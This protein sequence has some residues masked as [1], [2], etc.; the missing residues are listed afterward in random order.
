MNDF[1]A[2]D[3]ETASRSHNSACALGLVVVNDGA[4]A[5]KIKWFIR[6]PQNEYE[7]INISIHGIT[8]DQTTASPEF[9]EVWKEAQSFI[10]KNLVVA[11][12]AT[13]SDIS[14]IRDSSAHFDYTPNDFSYVCTRDM[15]RLFWPDRISYG[16]STLSAEFGIDLD[17]HDP[18]SDATAAAHLALLICDR[19]K[20]KSLTDAAAKIGYHLRQFSDRIESSNRIGSSNI[21]EFSSNLLE[22]AARAK[23][24]LA[25]HGPVENTIFL[26]GK[27]ILF[28]GTLSLMK[29]K[30]AE[31]LASEAGASI[32]KSLNNRIDYLIIGIQ[33]R[34]IV[35]AD[36]LSSKMKRAEEL[37][38]KGHKIEMID[39]EEFYIA[40]G[41]DETTDA[42]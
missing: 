20:A 29:R 36:G 16:L 28:T 19:T 34:N 33:N 23:E 15:A 1:V 26:K 31:K 25:E 18:V 3:L 6:P 39:E 7:D 30:E 2:I 14:F 11:H 12:S 22:A 13:S 35:G 8:P 10:G 42:M 38:A 9:P 37:A 40:L 21:S 4:I 24:K 17:H 5:E 32:E 27:N 41:M